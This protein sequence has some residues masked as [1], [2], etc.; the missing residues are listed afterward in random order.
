MPERIVQFGTGAFLRGFVGHFVDQANRQG[1]GAGRIVAVASTASGRE[2]RLNQQDGLYTLVV[3]GIDGGRAYRRLQLIASTSRAL[4]AAAEWDRVLD[5]ARNPEL[6]LVVSNT[7]EI[8]IAFD[9]ADTFEAAPPR[10][11]PGKLTRFLFERA[12]TFDYDAAR[13]VTVLPC[14]LVEDNGALLERIVLQ[15]A[16]HWRLPAQFADW[17]DA[18][19]PFCNTLVDRIVP[20]TPDDVTREALWQ[21]LGYRD[22]LITA[23]EPY[24]LFAIEAPSNLPQ[25]RFAQAD[26]AVV[27]TDDISPY[28]ERKVR[29]L[30][31]AHTILVPT[32]LLCGAE[33]VLE[34]VEHEAIGAFLRQVL[35][36]ELMP[37]VDVAGAEPFAEAVL[38]R[39]ANPFIS[40][41]LLDITLQQTMKMRVRVVPSILGYAARFGRAPRSIAF[42]LAAFL[43]YHRRNGEAQSARPDD[44]AEQ[45]RA[46]WRHTDS[47]N[48]GALLRL[49]EDALSRLA[50]WGTDLTRVPGF[51]SAVGEDLVM[52]V[53]RGPLAALDAHLATAVRA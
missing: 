50:L 34:A 37:S 41:A 2:A 33:T 40:H 22:D 3:Q 47:A 30:N 21:E 31:G 9:E 43:L 26:P 44:Q 24:R 16:E 5:V 13:G 29:L 25:L 28:R 38:D 15:T 8:G 10:S 32:A 17:I 35:M 42:G 18:A 27:I 45:L 19:V 51:A 48:P 20:G 39:F 1:L 6:E 49:A 52:L 11:F 36:T 12:R 23:C 7:T 53:R 4:S 14:E 46:L